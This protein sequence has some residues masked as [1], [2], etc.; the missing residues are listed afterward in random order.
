MA[1][2]SPRYFKKTPQW[3]GEAAD[4][5]MEFALGRA[6]MVADMKARRGQGYRAKHK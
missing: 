1:I 3:F 2:Q 4:W 5:L 6:R